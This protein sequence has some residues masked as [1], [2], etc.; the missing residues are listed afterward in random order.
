MIKITFVN[1]QAP[2]LNATNL[3]QLQTNIENAI[4]G[5]ILS[6]TSLPATADEGQIFLLYSSN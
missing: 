5:L 1:G 3:N 6:G 4:N 2:A